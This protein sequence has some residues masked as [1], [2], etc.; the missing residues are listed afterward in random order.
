MSRVL[1][2]AG[3]VAA[4]TAVPP[5]SSSSGAGPAAEPPAAGPA[6]TLVSATEIPL[7]ENYELWEWY[8]TSPDLPRGGLER[9]GTGPRAYYHNLEEPFRINARRESAELV[10]EREN[11]DR[12]SV[13]RQPPA[14]VWTRRIPVPGEDAPVVSVTED[15]VII[16]VRT[17]GGYRMFVL[18]PRDGRG[19]QDNLTVED[20]P[21]ASY[22]GEARIQHLLTGLLLYVYVRGTE[23]AHRDVLG[24][25]FGDRPALSRQTFDRT[26]LNGGFTPPP[27]LLRGRALGT[28]WPGSD[29]SYNVTSRGEKATVTSR[30]RDGLERWHAEFDSARPDIDRAAVLEIGD[31]VLVLVYSGKAS[32][33][34]ITGLDRTTGA[35]RWHDWAEEVGGIRP[36]DAQQRDERYHN[37]VGLIPA[38]GPRLLVYGDETDGQYISVFDL[39]VGLRL[40]FEVW[41]R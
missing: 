26:Y 15:R 36:F 11:L 24:L 5:Q 32:G 29:G 4:C 31:L 38:A 17:P 10:L 9:R 3:L 20:P 21:G 40:G 27:N 22:G 6:P 37:E 2:L 14:I 34:G 28:D 1:V 30:G 7:V 33:A 16:T 19:P 8:H 39:N 41:P 23:S 18:D 35:R 12:G 13:A 25:D